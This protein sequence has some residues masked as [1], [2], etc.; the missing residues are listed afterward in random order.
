MICMFNDVSCHEREVVP[1][2]VHLLWSYPTFSD[3]LPGLVIKAL[4]G[5]HSVEAERQ[6]RSLADGT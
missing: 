3:C 2:N 6:L 4:V 5:S 1:Y